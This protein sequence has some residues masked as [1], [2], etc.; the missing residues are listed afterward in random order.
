M[1]SSRYGSIVRA[2]ASIPEVYISNSV[3]GKIYN[4]HV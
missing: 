1:G 4:E 3:I 2:V